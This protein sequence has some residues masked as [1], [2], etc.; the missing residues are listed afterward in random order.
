MGGGGRRQQV[1]ASGLCGFVQ[2]SLG[3]MGH[4]RAHRGGVWES[5]RAAARVGA[6]FVI[7]RRSCPSL[8][9]LR[10]GN[11]MRQGYEIGRYGYRWYSH[12]NSRG[13]LMA[14]LRDYLDAIA[15]SSSTCAVFAE[16]N[17][18]ERTTLRRLRFVAPLLYAQLIHLRLLSWMHRP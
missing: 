11:L 8:E 5:T 1:E 4:Y 16:R 7:T 6:N 3:Q 15:T 9:I 2:P 14:S 18:V 10:G 13:A 17:C 12:V